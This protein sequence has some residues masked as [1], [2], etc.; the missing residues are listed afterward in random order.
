M[1][2]KV[3]F[4]FHER[5]FINRFLAAPAKEKSMFHVELSHKLPEVRNLE[6]LIAFIDKSF[7]SNISI[8][9]PLM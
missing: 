8:E 2:R 6:T 3:L 9:K 7:K 5:I 4:S 1:W